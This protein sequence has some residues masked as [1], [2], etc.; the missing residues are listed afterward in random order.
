MSLFEWI[1]TTFPSDS[2]NDCFI[3]VPREPGNPGKG[4]FWTLDPLAEDMFDNGSFLRRRK[5]YK[6][7]Q[8]HHN[9]PFPMFAPFNHPFWVR[10]PVPVLPSIPFPPS[11]HHPSAHHPHHPSFNANFNLM[12]F[13]GS[14]HSMMPT[15][16]ISHKKEFYDANTIQSIKSELLNNN[17]TISASSKVFSSG[18]QE[19]SFANSF[20]D[21]DYATDNIDVETDSDT[22][23]QI[24]ELKQM[25]YH[26][27]SDATVKHEEWSRIVKN[28]MLKSNHPPKHSENDSS[29]VGNQ[30]DLTSQHDIS[31]EVKIDSDTDLEKCANVT[32]TSLKRV[33]LPDEDD[34]EYFNESFTSANLLNLSDRKR[35]KYGNGRGFSIENIIGRMVEDR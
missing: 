23:P 16:K 21:D 13:R 26:S 15:E 32:R 4:N 5:R 28:S 29:H 7:I 3:K 8:M 25:N 35:G 2:L 27:L 31:S 34:A 22:D 9:L 30:D 6:R 33:F 11:M 19:Q 20:E 17:T 18:G 12:S 1:S 14:N 10:K 24:T